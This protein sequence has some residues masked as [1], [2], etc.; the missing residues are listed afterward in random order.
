[1]GRKISLQQ[2]VAEVKWDLAISRWKNFGDT[3][4][5]R[6]LQAAGVKSERG[7]KFLN[8]EISR[9]R[10]GKAK[11]QA[12][13]HRM[14]DEDVVQLVMIQKLRFGVSFTNNNKEMDDNPCVVEVALNHDVN[15]A[16]VAKRFKRVPAERR[17]QI[18]AGVKKLL[19]EHGYLHPKHQGS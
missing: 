11:L 9:P 12:G 8:G 19:A 1:M 15:P 10:G 4:E 18:E 6:R 14:T 2:M 3:S 7:Q 5:I 13:P 17:R 16:Y